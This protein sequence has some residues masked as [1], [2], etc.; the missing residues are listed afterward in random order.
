MWIAFG[1]WKDFW[2]IPAREVVGIL[3]QD[4]CVALPVF[5][6]KTGCD[7]VSFLG[8]RG[9]KTAWNIWQTFDDVTPAVLCFGCNT[10][11]S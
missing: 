5:H 4:R 9:K 7:T 1:I 3:G 8:G 11:P 10:K 6:A 2:H